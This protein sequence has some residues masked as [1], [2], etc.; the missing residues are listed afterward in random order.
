MR[1]VQIKLAL[2][3]IITVM[4][5]SFLATFLSALVNGILI[6]SG[7]STSIFL[8]FALKEILTPIITVL[9]TIMIAA[10]MSK[11]A[12]FPVV[13][14][15]RATKQI[16]AGNYD[17]NITG[18]ERKDEFGQLARD[19]LLMAQE[20][21]TNELLA[22]DFISNVSHEFRTPLAVIS[23]YTKLL[24][25]DELT[26]TERH[27]YSLKIQNEAERLIKLSSNILRLS[28]LDNQKIQDPPSLFLLDEQLRQVILS[29]EPEWSAKDISLDI[30][31]PAITWLGNEA[32]LAQVWSNILDNAIKFSCNKG[33]IGVRASS[34]ENQIVVEISDHGIGMDEDTQTR[35]FER[36]YQGDSSHS[37]QGNGLGLALVKQIMDIL[38]GR[39]T[40]R[41]KPG[42]GSVFTVVIPA[43][44]AAD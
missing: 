21:K 28:K 24:D 30:D 43:Y 15:S 2:F 8:G 17:I 32:L 19:F 34:N 39:I 35:I 31:I 12:V 33:E 1:R 23:G 22:K 26:K 20:L 18:S 44:R 41:S 10:T 3:L 13:S 6:R 27:S 11:R 5:S 14:L 25:S 36:F 16:A 4:T 37:G 9:L 29:L 40:V 42:A 38:G 7:V